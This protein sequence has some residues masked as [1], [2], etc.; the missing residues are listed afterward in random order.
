MIFYLSPLSGQLA[1][2]LARTHH[3]PELWHNLLKWCSSGASACRFIIR[4]AFDQLVADFDLWQIPPGLPMNVRLEIFDGFYS[5]CPSNQPTA[6]PP[7][8]GQL[9]TFWHVWSFPQ[10]LLCYVMSVTFARWLPIYHS[11]S[12]SDPISDYLMSPCQMSASLL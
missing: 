9:M 10:G 12:S 2:I 4:P 7:I 11:N 3:A 8:A 1:A 6:S 5:S